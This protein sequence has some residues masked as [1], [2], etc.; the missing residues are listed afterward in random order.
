MAADKSFAKLMTELGARQHRGPSGMTDWWVLDE[1]D[2][3]FYLGFNFEDDPE[4]P[5][6]RYTCDIHLCYVGSSP[7]DSKDSFRVFAN[8]RGHHVLRFM[9]ALGVS[10]FS[11]QTKKAMYA[12]HGVIRTNDGEFQRLSDGKTTTAD[13]PKRGVWYSAGVTCGYWTDDWSKLTT[14]GGIPCCPKCR[15]V[16]M[17]TTADDWFSG[18]EKFQTD[19]SRYLEF[20]EWVKEKCDR[21]D[22]KEKF[23]DRYRRW[24]ASQDGSVVPSVKPG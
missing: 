1:F 12:H 4:T 10:R 17:Q 11:E 19:H 24:L 9:F 14:N 20:L 15:C 8:A 13:D 22:R 6:A 3:E 7:Q 5:E 16:G 18:A 21:H 2:H 23:L